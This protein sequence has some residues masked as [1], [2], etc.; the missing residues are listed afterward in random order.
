M[1]QY[2][3]FLAA[4]SSY[5][6]DLLSF[7]AMEEILRLPPEHDGAV[8]HYVNAGPRRLMHRH[9]DPLGKVPLRWRSMRTRATPLSSIRVRF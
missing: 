4:A 2:A 7:S 5:L 3:P 1:T 9:A 8:Y 6:R